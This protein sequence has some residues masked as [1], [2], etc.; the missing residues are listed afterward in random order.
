MLKEMV[1]MAAFLLALSGI[2]A[3]ALIVERAS[4][5][6]YSAVYRVIEYTNEIN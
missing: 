1:T 5:R 4:F 2:A 6:Q 3:G